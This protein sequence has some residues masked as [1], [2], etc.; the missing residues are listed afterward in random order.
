MNGNKSD[1]KLKNERELRFYRWLYQNESALLNYQL[2]PVV[3]ALNIS[4]LYSLDIKR[5][6]RV[7]NSAVRSFYHPDIAN[8][9]GRASRG[10][11]TENFIPSR[12]FAWFKKCQ[13]ACYY[14]WIAIRTL[15]IK[16]LPVAFSSLEVNDYGSPFVPVIL[17]YDYLDLIQYPASHTERLLTIT[18]FFDRCDS[19]LKG[20]MDLLNAIR[21]EWYR[22]YNY[23]DVF[24]LT[25]KEKEKC[26]WAW[27]YLQKDRANIKAGAKKRKENKESER[28]EQENNSQGAL[29]N[30]SGEMDA[31]D[32]K[33]T[34][35]IVTLTQVTQRMSQQHPISTLTEFA[36]HD[37]SSARD[38][39]YA[40]HSSLKD[41]S[42]DSANINTITLMQYLKP[43]SNA[44]KRLIIRCL[45]TCWYHKDTVFLKRFNKAWEGVHFRKKSRSIKK[46][47]QSPETS[48][49]D[50]IDVTANQIPSIA[51]SPREKTL[52]EAL[53]EVCE[54][55]Q[56]LP[57][58]DEDAK[59]NNNKPFMD[60][61]Y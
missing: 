13:D 50:N 56:T 47:T 32:N 22:L 8:T 52:S 45:Y 3:N 61:P 55:N 12:D 7:I 42:E 2:K 23:K 28:K 59:K 19:S 58:A 26:E 34:L 29:H 40:T 48:E 20:K 24:P 49:V 54:Q 25:K 30:S 5:A 27:K 37:P 1:V 60:F 21:A 53:R 31:Q 57:S 46:S 16:T 44:E 18:D 14:V 10:H 11:I 41:I 51:E 35:H 15:N 6:S 33:Q 38:N 9:F 43:S 36:Q 39:D 4:Y 17:T